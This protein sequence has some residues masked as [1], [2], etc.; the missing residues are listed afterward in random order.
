MIALNWARIRATNRINVPKPVSY[1]QGDKSMGSLCKDK[2]TTH[3][4][5]MLMLKDR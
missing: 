3:Y 1:D 2:K 5:C 4:L